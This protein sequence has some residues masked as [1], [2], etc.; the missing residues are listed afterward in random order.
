MYCGPD[1][2]VQRAV[3]PLT[4]ADKIRIPFAVVHSEQDWRCP[5]EQGQRMFV[6]L[7]RNGTPTELLLFPG[8][9]H[10]LTRSGRPVHRKQLFDAVLGW[11]QRHLGE[12]VGTGDR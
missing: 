7:K 2:D 6:A 11:W 4:Y 9:G 8:E 12:S 3:S 5:L 10:E 1:P